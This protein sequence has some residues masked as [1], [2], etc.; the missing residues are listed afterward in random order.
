MGLI[1]SNGIFLWGRQRMVYVAGVELNAI[2]YGLCWSMLV[3]RLFQE[4][5]V[6]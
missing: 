4:D 5:W 6:L 2:R 3:P 1:N